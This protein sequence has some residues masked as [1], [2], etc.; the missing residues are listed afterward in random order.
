MDSSQGGKVDITF[1]DVYRYSVLAKEEKQLYNYETLS[2]EH[3]DAEFKRSIVWNL[4]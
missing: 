3:T 1:R 2:K 4:I